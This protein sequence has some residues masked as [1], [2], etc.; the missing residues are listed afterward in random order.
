MKNLRSKNLVYLA[1]F[2]FLIFLTSLGLIYGKEFLKLS[3]WKEQSSISFKE[4]S[5]IKNKESFEDSK[6]GLIEATLEVNNEKYEAEIPEGSTV[7][8]LMLCLQKKYN[9]FSFSG[10][11]FSGL[12]FFVEEINGL[13]QDKDKGFYWIY[14]INNKVAPLGVSNYKLKNK[15]NI[16][17]KYE[18]TY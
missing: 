3:T 13:K 1:I 11:E 6:I 12:G 9:N 8:D 14:Y 15:D 5:L 17:W 7:Y 16:T 4:E 18:K 2:G 10:R